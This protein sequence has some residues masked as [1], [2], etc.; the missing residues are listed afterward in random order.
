MSN[1]WENIIK[2]TKKQKTQFYE[3]EKGL[4]LDSDMAGILVFKTI[5]TNM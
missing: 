5:V 1:Y 4:E 3:T 2:C